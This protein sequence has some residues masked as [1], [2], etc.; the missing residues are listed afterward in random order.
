M[1]R[2]PVVTKEQSEDF[3]K[4]L[5]HDYWRTPA[6]RDGDPAFRAQ[7]ARELTDSEV[8]PP[9]G[10]D[11]R[12]FVK[13]MG[14]SVAL[15]GLAACR[16][17]EEKILPYAHAPEDLIPGRPALYAT[18]VAWAG[19]AVGLLVE[20]HEGRPTKVEGNPQHPDSLGATNA[21][22]QGLIIDLYDPDRSTGPQSAGKDASWADAEAAIAQISAAVRAKAG[23][24]LAI[25]VQDHRSPTTQ[26]A[27]EALRRDMPEAK[28]AQWEAFGRD[29]ARKG[30]EIAFGKAADAVYDFAKADVVLT[31]DADP[32]GADGSS[33]KHSKGWAKRRRAEDG[34]MIRV[35][36]AESAPS[37]T[38]FAAD[39]RLRI[40]SRK[41]PALAGA[42][43]AALGVP[44]GTAKLDANAD[45]KAPA[46]ATAVAKD[47]QRRAAAA[48]VIAGR[49]QPPA[50]HALAAAINEKI[51][52]VGSTVR[53][54]PVVD[55]VPSGA[56]A[57]KALIAS[58]PDTVIVLGGNPVFDAPADIDVKGLLARTRSVHVSSHVDETSAACKWHI[59]RA[60]ALEGWSDTMAE[61]GTPSVT[62]PLIAPMHGGKTDA[63]ILERLVGGTRNA[64]D[65]VR[66]TWAG[67][68]GGLTMP[69][70]AGFEKSWRKVVHD[71]LQLGVALA[72]VPATVDAG[73]LGREL[74]ALKPA[75]GAVEV[76]FAPDPHAWDGRFANASWLQELPDP[77]HK[78]TWANAA[79]I[80][81]ATAKKLG[82]QSGDHVTVSVGGATV[83]LPCIISFGQA[84]DSVALTSG[85]GR[86]VVGRVGSGVGF[87]TYPLRKEAGLDIAAGTIAKAAGHTKL[88][89]TQGHFSLDGRPLVREQTLEAFDK[90]PT[91]AK[92]LVHFPEPVNLFQGFE[93]HGHKWA[94]A[95]DL[96]LCT[97]CGSCV[98]ACQAENNTT[99]VGPEGVLRNR[100]MHW[101]R[102]DRYF[103]GSE[104][105]PKSVV[106]PMLCQHCENAPCEQV[107][108]VNA[109]T[110]SPEGINEMTYNR[111][112]GTKYCGNNCP[113]KVRRFNYF[114]YTK[115]MPGTTALAMNPD[116]TVR[117]RGVME[118]CSFCVQ[119]VNEA[120]IVAKTQD[121]RT[122]LRDGEVVA[123]CEQSCPTGA[124]TFGD[125]NDG[126]SRVSKAIDLPRS[127]KILEELNVRPRVNYLARIM[128]PNPELEKA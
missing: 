10:V 107:C 113:Y 85:Q 88:P 15:A 93:Y 48:L 76:T 97:G 44:A 116:V 41:I 14:A 105:E 72:P 30:A 112:I 1:K 103:E 36:A 90:D 35:Y 60:H 2:L 109:T 117:S 115:D 4:V 125:L 24:G 23:K 121:G 77:I 11:R 67:M 46:F 54:V 49:K 7:Q 66:S 29:N 87:D 78:M 13:L 114:N 123:A 16:R 52:A 73:A 61:D 18:S 56:A 43:A 100:E 12:S 68:F 22:H 57:L 59:P 69:T 19:T 28:V 82:V 65:L 79:G 58:A 92:K 104:D 74:A 128:N 45:P 3:A 51:G 25:L 118:K 70:G 83:E 27:L 40:Q 55:D 50:V 99:I 124:I 98:T 17:P 39:H 101:I 106:Q 64:Y 84:D 37:E 31:L 102:I 96:S 20:S 38:G 42:V 8:Q 5:G 33:V 53:Y 89:I 80:S 126:Q 110:H 71:G 91:W 32:L 21:F 127:Y 6:D 63:E 86:K 9:D 108:P 95:I 26:R 122:R 34:K 75:D 120:K 94:M 119:R 111:C 47:L 81:P 62:Q